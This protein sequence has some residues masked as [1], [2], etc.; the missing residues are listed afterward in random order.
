MLR[1]IGIGFLALAVVLSVLGAGGF[2]A[3]TADRDTSVAV[4]DDSQAY[5]GIDADGCE[6]TNNLDRSV[7]VALQS[8]GSDES[9]DSTVE[10]GPGESDDVE[11]DGETTIEVEGNGISSELDRQ[12][13]CAPEPDDDEATED[14][15]DGA[16][17]IQEPMDD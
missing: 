5:V 10:L 3:A 11:L 15:D 2:G 12:F 13:D 7:T 4:V 14:A 8:D 1:T 16:I 6:I 17:E 9:D